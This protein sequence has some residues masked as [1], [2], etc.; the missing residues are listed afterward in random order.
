MQASLRFSEDFI[1]NLTRNNI[2]IITFFSSYTAET[3]LS[4]LKNISDQLAI[5]KYTKKITICVLSKK[6]KNIIKNSKIDFAKIE[7]AEYP[8]QTSLLEMINSYNIL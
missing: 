6:I 1:T 3:F 8:N 2:A 5:S 7:A 4:L